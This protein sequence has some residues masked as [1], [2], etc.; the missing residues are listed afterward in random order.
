M[1]NIEFSNRIDEVKWLQEQLIKE[2][3]VD[4]A[5]L[6]E[7]VQNT[8]SLKSVLESKNQ[9]D[10]FNAAN[11][12][13]EWCLADMQIMP[14]QDAVNKRWAAYVLALQIKL[15]FLGENPWPLNGMRWEKTAEAV[16]SLQRKKWLKVDWIAWKFMLE[17]M[18]VAIN[19]KNELDKGLKKIWEIN[20]MLHWTHYTIEDGKFVL[21]VP[22]EKLQK[23]T[24]L[25]I[26][27]ATDISSIS[28]LSNLKSLYLENCN[29]RDVSVLSSLSNLESLALN[30][31]NITNIS[32]LASLSN[33]KWLWLNN[34]KIKDISALSSLSNLKSLYLENNNITNISALS[35]LS[36]LERLW[37]KNN[38]IHDISM[39]SWLSNLRM[40]WLENNNITNIP[41]LNWLSN[42]R[43]LSLNNNKITDK[44]LVNLSFISNLTV[45][46]LENNN[47]NN[48]SALSSVS[49]L[50]LV[51]LANNNITDISGLSSLSSLEE[52]D[53][54]KNN[55]SQVWQLI[56]NN[57]LRILLLWNQWIPWLQ[58]NAYQ[59]QVSKLISSLPTLKK[60]EL[61]HTM[62]DLE[63]WLKL[64]NPNLNVSYA[65]STS[66]P[67]Q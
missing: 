66:I 44:D 25:S 17:K 46:Y 19:H 30:N 13:L 54:R 38:N 31:N 45:L 60:V 43:L 34:N 2:L 58:E 6:E 64:S 29:I 62:K 3:K 63:Q 52:I 1:N 18:L 57:K 59:S 20:I 53:L 28:W 14:F 48:I 22:I 26:K 24:E 5:S 33:L 41:P 40:L 27:E 12:I 67:G 49:N 47:I 21:L 7:E 10:I 50:K 16:K 15:K 4:I 56:K 11:R 23:V 42:L 37:L 9:Q 8:N 39:L 65:D 32:A 51:W 61:W 35:S 55:I 36:N